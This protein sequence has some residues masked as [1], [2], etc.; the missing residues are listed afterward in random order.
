MGNDKHS[1]VVD[2]YQRSW[3]HD[4]LYLVG[5]GSMPT[6]ATANTTLTLAALCFRSAGAMLSHL[7]TGQYRTAA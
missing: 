1:S 2:T 5:A 4:N 6:I 7:A 3:E